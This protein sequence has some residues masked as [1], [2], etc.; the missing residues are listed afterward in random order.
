MDP[1]AWAVFRWRLLLLPHIPLNLAVG[2]GTL[3]LGTFLLINL[4]SFIPSVVLYAL[5]GGA[6][7]TWAMEH[8]W[9]MAAILVGSMAGFAVLGLVRQKAARR[10]DKSTSG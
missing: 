4:V 5:I 6:V 10:R 3:H 8:P 2:A 9:E 7:R 1:R